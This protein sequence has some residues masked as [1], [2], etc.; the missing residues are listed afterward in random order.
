MEHELFQS[1][2]K[3]P[4]DAI[5]ISGIIRSSSS[6]LN[7]HRMATMELILERTIRERRERMFGKAKNSVRPDPTPQ[8]KRA[9][10]VPSIPTPEVQPAPL[11]LHHGL[12]P[13]LRLMT[14]VLEMPQASRLSPSS[15]KHCQTR[16]FPRN[17]QKRS[18]RNHRY[19][20][21]RTRLH[22]RIFWN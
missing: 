21:T 2:L 15:T 5:L 9:S 4:I 22:Q 1:K 6:S 16:R 17:P 12:H 7:S 3:S 8:P 10:E 13:S 18:R 14:V 19:M 20:S 11:L